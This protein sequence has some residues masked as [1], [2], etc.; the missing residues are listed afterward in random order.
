MGRARWWARPTAP[1][2]TPSEAGRRCGRRRSSATGRMRC[3][4]TPAKQH[5]ALQRVL[6]KA[7]ACWAC[8]P[9]TNRCRQPG[10]DLPGTFLELDSLLP[11]AARARRLQALGITPRT[12]DA[13]PGGG[14]FPFVLFAAPPSG[15]EDYLGEIKAALGLWDGTGAFVFTS[16]AGVY[17]VEDGSGGCWPFVWVLLGCGSFGRQCGP[18]GRCGHCQRH[19]ACPLSRMGQAAAA[20]PSLPAGC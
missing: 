4:S 14:A 18:G 20:R 5:V 16:S 8:S 9:R 1:P 12:K 7:L 19:P 2:T 3:G 6:T 10:G 15:S 17:T 13:A 11:A